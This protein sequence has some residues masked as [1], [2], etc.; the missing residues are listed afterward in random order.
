MS[1]SVQ[2]IP[3][4]FVRHYAPYCLSS[5][6]RA[7]PL[8]LDFTC[9][10]HSVFLGSKTVAVAPVYLL[11]RNC[12]LSAF[13]PLFCHFH[14]CVQLWVEATFSAEAERLTAYQRASDTQISIINNLSCLHIPSLNA[15]ITYHH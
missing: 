2:P 13:L 1:G 10:C 9:I 15:S 3:L 4:H 6:K 7:K 11:W 5:P 8:F 12:K 14:S